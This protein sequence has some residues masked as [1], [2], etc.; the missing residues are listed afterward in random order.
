MLP[1][2]DDRL[3]GE[4]QITPLAFRANT[5]VQSS[6]GCGPG[7]T[8]PL[9]SFQALSCCP[10]ALI[11]DPVSR[12]EAARLHLYQAEPIGAYPV[13]R[14]GHRGADGLVDWSSRL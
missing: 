7:D 13:R 9:G 10:G 11:P 8:R 3:R 12:V 4:G 1:P 6:S 14:G 5:G 2:A